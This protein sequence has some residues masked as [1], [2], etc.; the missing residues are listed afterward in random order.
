MLGPDEILLAGMEG[1]AKT[2]AHGPNVN[3]GCGWIGWGGWQMGLSR[4][5]SVPNVFDVEFPPMA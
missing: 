2:L 5:G 4:L 3:F 1:D